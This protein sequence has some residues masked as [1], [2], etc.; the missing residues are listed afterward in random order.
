MPEYRLPHPIEQRLAKSLQGHRNRYDAITL[1]VFLARY[2][3]S[4]RKLGL[5]FPADRRRLAEIPALGL[6]EAR[7]RSALRTLEAVGFLDRVEQLGSLYQRT[8]EGPHRKP[9]LYRFAAEYL[10][11]FKAAN[12]RSA[13]HRQSES[14]AQSVRPTSTLRKPTHKHTVSTGPLLMGSS[15][16]GNALEAALARLGEAMRRVP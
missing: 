16:P 11:Q 8:V 3:S 6:S 7:V 9:I 10:P 15:E 5:V 2:W 13:K 4:P 14:Q 1:A 12:C